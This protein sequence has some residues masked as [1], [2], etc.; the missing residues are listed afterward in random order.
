MHVVLIPAYEPGARLVDLVRELACESPVLVVDDGSGPRY[1]PV[2]AAAA[3]AGAVVVAHDRNFE[4]TLA[5][6]AVDCQNLVALH[7]AQRG[8]KVII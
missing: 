7:A 3:D 6:A 4:R 1:A 8:F 2:F 5:L